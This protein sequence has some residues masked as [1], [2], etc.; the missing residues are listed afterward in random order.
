MVSLFLKTVF[1][2]PIMV[3]KSGGMRI[4]L[5]VVSYA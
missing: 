4:P 2:V 1:Q 3:N 5:A